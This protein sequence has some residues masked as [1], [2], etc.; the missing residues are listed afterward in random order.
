MA[1]Q[2]V[3]KSWVVFLPELTQFRALQH[4]MG[5]VCAL[6]KHRDKKG[7][8]LGQQLH[9]RALIKSYK[10]SLLIHASLVETT[11]LSAESHPP[12]SLPADVLAGDQSALVAH[13]AP[14]TREDNHHTLVM[15]QEPGD[16]V[17]AMNSLKIMSF[18]EH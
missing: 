11:M 13:P 2:G 4:R 5:L 17:T 10:K 6:R 14:P 8:S 16:L 3:K 1:A 12:V 9:P 18:E 15:T 7:I